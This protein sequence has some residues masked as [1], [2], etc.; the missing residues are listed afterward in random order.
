[1]ATPGPRRG[2]GRRE[3][4]LREAARLFAERGFHGTTIEDIGAAGG[5]SG[6]G[7]YKHFASK[8]AVLAS[9]LVGI[10]ERLLEGGRAQVEQAAGD[11][12]ALA[13]LVASH[14]EFALRDPDLNIYQTYDL[15]LIKGGTST[16]LLHN[17]PVAPSDVGD[18][19]MPAYE[20]L[21]DAAISRFGGASG[22]TSGPHRAGRPGLTCW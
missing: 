20:S 15:T 16:V 3:V 4:L 18:T 1:M 2:S 7:V 8:D 10:S 22:T 17:A 13:R 14:A 12:D 9:L 6:P 11:A 19:S 21:R 5:I